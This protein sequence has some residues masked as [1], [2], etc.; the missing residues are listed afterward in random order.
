MSTLGI[1]L[2]RLCRLLKKK[3]L[4]YL[5]YIIDAKLLKYKREDEMIYILLYVVIFKHYILHIYI[6]I[7]IYIYIHIY[8]CLNYRIFFS[9]I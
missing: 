9:H 6:Y 4:I 5:Y 2:C 3:P 1:T 8:I 7:Y